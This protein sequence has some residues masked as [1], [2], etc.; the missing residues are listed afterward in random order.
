MRSAGRAC[1]SWAANGM[2][3]RFCG[4]QNKQQT[5]LCKALTRNLDFSHLPTSRATA[6]LHALPLWGSRAHSRALGHE[7]SIS[8]TP[9][10]AAASCGGAGVLRGCRFGR[11]RRSR[12]RPSAGCPYHHWHSRFGQPG[13]PSY[14]HTT[15]RLVTPGSLAQRW[16]GKHHTHG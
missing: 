6:R 15:V 4:G 5:R 8:M 11:C 7:S 2:L 10:G 12:C 9:G 14:S 13:P 3:L 1:G 16:H